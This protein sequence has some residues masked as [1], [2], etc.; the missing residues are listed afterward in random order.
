MQ[1][2]GKEHMAAS[3]LS[4]LFRG[5][6][7]AEPGENCTFEDTS[8]IEKLLSLPLLIDL[9]FDTQE[10]IFRTLTHSLLYHISNQEAAKEVYTL[11]MVLS[12]MEKLV[13]ASLGAHLLEKQVEEIAK[14]G[15]T[16]KTAESILHL[17]AMVSCSIR[18]S[19]R[20]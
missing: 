15:I 17:V 14:T 9:T 16:G 3:L 13:D 18:Y 5:H 2:S 12:L 6:G 11:S 4:R 20:I 7:Q 1:M 10:R 8:A 19:F